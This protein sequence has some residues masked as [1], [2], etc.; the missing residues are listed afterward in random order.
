MTDNEIIK[1]LECCILCEC[2]NCPHDGE[3]ACKENLNQEILDLITRQKEEK[4]ALIA[5]QETLQRHIAEQKAEIERLQGEKENCRCV[6]ADLCEQVKTAKAEAIKEYM[7][8]VKAGLIKGGIYPVLVKNTLDRVK[9]E[10]V[11][12]VG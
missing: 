11:G 12:D 9:E 8:R 10:M 7:K 5:G 3:T 1:A 6:I 2:E 4:E